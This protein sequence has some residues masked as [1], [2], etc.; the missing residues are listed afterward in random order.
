MREG[1][2]DELKVGYC[3][4][5]KHNG[6]LGKITE[7]KISDFGD[8]QLS[9]YKEESNFT[10]NSWSLRQIVENWFIVSPD[11]YELFLALSN[12][13]TRQWGNEHGVLP[14]P[15][16]A[17]VSDIYEANEPSVTI[18]KMLFVN[19]ADQIMRD[20]CPFKEGED[21]TEIKLCI[22]ELPYKTTKE[23][24]DELVFPPVDENGIITAGEALD[25]MDEAVQQFGA[26]IDNLKVTSESEE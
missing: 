4:L 21:G 9:F 13:S 26:V 24:M 5:N 17:F 20:Y 8:R 6:N 2:Q 3:L 16:F 25:N 11:E 18:D 15:L 23:Q 14:A 19:C 7:E 10:T 1:T 12:T 22:A